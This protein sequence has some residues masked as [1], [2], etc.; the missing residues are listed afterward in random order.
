[1]KARRTLLSNLI[2][3]HELG[4]PNYLEDVNFTRDALDVSHVRDFV[5]LEDF[6]GNLKGQHPF[7]T[8]PF[9]L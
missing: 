6:D 4:V 3:L 8:L 5:L 2:E 9:R 7:L 1:M